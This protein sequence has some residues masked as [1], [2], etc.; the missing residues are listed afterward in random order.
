MTPPPASTPRSA[1]LRS[2]PL[3]G[4]TLLAILF[5]GTFNL[6]QHRAWYSS[7][8]GN[9]AGLGGDFVERATDSPPLPDIYLDTDSLYWLHHATRLLDGGPWRTRHID[10]D[11][12]PLGR[13]NHWNSALVWIMAGT[14][15][16]SALITNRPAA[17]MLPLTAPWINP[18]LFVLLLGA[19][20][21]VLRRRLAPWPAGLLVFSLATL[22]PVM[23]SFGVL[24]IDHHGL[25][26]IP[27]VGMP[28]SLLFGITAATSARRRW[29]LAAGILG[30][31]GLWFQASHQLILI[32][33]ALA[34]LLLWSVFRPGLDD[35]LPAA[36]LW[37]LWAGAGALV[38]LAAYLL[39]YAPAHLGMQ[40]AVNHP[41][42]ALSWYGGTEAILAL[43]RARRFRQWT[44]SRLAVMTA[45]LLPGVATLLLMRH[46]PESWFPVASPFLLRIHEQIREFQPLLKTVRGVNPLLLFPLFNTLPLL[47]LLGIG[48]GCS[49]NMPS[50]ERLALHVALAGL[51]PAFALSLR[52]TRYSGLLATALWIAA[53]AV[54]MARPHGLSG[55]RI[56]RLPPVLLALGGAAGLALALSPLLDTRHPFMP[57]V[58]WVPQMIQRDI[59]RELAR[60]PG[61]AGRA[62]LCDYNIAPHL[63][64]FAGARTTGGLYWE[65]LDGLHAAA[66]CFAAARDDDA[67]RLL[68]E[69]DIR[70]IVV[71]AKPN[72]AAAW[73][74][75]LHANQHRLNPQATLAARLASD[76]PPPRWLQRVPPDDT[77]LAAKARYRVFRVE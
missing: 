62:V 33:A 47:A 73:L 29:F 49:K 59:A 60:L 13:S 20:A 16:V 25:I 55:R 44:P 8:R 74:Y 43:A 12:A 3:W 51:L 53:V 11:N 54:F 32:A 36:S 14:A 21:S 7:T 4:L 22:P 10:W 30:G 48:L 76:R 65:N 64:A 28:L 17:E 40:L 50:R 63:Q 70:W 75:Y 18:M 34:A 58:R 19:A 68:S 69:R 77:P 2:A 56:R 6:L 67:R 72:A 24:H 45:G 42:Y 26:D 9:E 15:R 38:S 39:E 37:R 46:G 66:E 27:A 52:H 61:F 5:W 31:L 23:W 35:D 1:F 71:E 57:V 41:L